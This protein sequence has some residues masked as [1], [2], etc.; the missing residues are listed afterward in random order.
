MARVRIDRDG[1]RVGKCFR[2]SSSARCAFRTTAEPGGGDRL[3]RQSWRSLPRSLTC[4][5]STSIMYDTHW[6]GHSIELAQS[7]GGV[8]AFRDAGDGLVHGDVVPWPPPE[9]V[10]K[11]YQSTHVSAYRDSDL[12]IVTSVH[13][14]YSDLQ[15]VHSEDALTWSLFGP[16][17]Y[18]PPEVRARFAGELL[19]ALEID[20]AEPES[21]NVW[22]WRRLPHP[23]TKVLGGPE[24]D[25]G[26]QTSRTLLLGEA[27][28]RS[29]IGT[30]QGKSGTKDQIQLRAEF[31][32]DL[33]G[34]FY[35]TV[36]NFVVV[37]A[38]RAIGALTAAHKSLSAGN[39]RVVETTWDLLGD[40]RANPWRGEF[41]AQ[42]SW[43]QA[44]SQP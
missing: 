12:A 31:C 37:L 23:D 38:S 18:S 43:R 36:E 10:Q 26:V 30:K 15:S 8:Y 1:I 44:H 24:V 9:L 2:S 4:Q 40:V 14:Y 5:P 39:V 29:G 33:G 3:M 27:K 35:P 22:L 25:F 34:R 42:L 6:K 16:I 7:A 11:L 41:R 21:A 13:G 20:D 28:W 32:A 17:A 19:K